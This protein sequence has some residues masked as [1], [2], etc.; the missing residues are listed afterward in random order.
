MET[1]KEVL[2]GISWSDCRV[3][4]S[5]FYQSAPNAVC[6]I[7]LVFKTIGPQ[8]SPALIEGN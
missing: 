2:A 5:K 1:R 8:A 4:K 6:T 3:A 7:R